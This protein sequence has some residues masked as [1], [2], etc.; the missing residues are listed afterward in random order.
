M[1]GPRAATAVVRVLAPAV[2]GLLLVLAGACGRSEPSAAP[3][4]GPTAE[5]DDGAPWSGRPSPRRRL[6]LNRAS[7]PE[8]EA[9]PGIG[10]VRA[11]SILAARNA[12]G[13]RFERLE[14]LLTIDGI[15][16]VTLEQI[17]G[18]VYLGRR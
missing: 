18:Q 4:A 10:A 12:R 8:L 15:G 9:L 16:Q 13:G 17:R 1:R 3:H 5:R 7:L 2:L 14:Q 6:G 11:R